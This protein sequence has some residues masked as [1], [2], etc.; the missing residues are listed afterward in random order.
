MQITEDQATEAARDTIPILDDP[1]ALFRD[2]LAEAEKTEPNDP[3]AMIVAT[4]G[5]DGLPTARAILLKGVDERGFVF[6]TNT[7]S[8]K[9][10]HLQENPQAGLCFYWK[11]LGRQVR[12]DGPV[13]PV[14][15]AEADA[16]FHSRPQ[17]SQIGA[18]ASQQSRPMPARKTLLDRVARYAG[19]FGE[20]AV[21]RPDYWSGYRVLPLRMEYWRDRPFRL[22]ER[23]IYRRAA[24]DAP[25]QTERLFP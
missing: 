20:G 19:E 15:A 7:Q 4:A 9:G 21:P 14:T 16:Y 2:W 6:Y 25:W 8:R 5:R 23:L 22:H 11:T 18:W 12:A 10:D 17:G 24:L 1:M 13:E 3:N